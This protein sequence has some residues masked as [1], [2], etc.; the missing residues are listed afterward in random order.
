MIWNWIDDQQ[1]RA[2]VLATGQEHLGRA[3][4]DVAAVGGAVAGA[5]DL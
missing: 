5:A 1:V 2:V 3:P 4:V